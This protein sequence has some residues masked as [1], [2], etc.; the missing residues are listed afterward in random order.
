[1]ETTKDIFF[2]NGAY[3][4]IPK[5]DIRISDHDEADAVALYKSNNFL[6]STLYWDVTDWQQS[7]D[8]IVDDLE[9]AGYVWIHF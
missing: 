5:F 2:F 8:N 4:Y 7:M 1:M 3:I 9:K 6:S